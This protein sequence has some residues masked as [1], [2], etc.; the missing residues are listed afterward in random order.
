MVSGCILGLLA[1]VLGAF[2]SHGLK[3]RI[4]A[5]AL[6]SFRTGVRYQMYHGLLLILVGMMPWLDNKAR[7]ILLFLVLIGLLFFSGSIYMLSTREISGLD[8]SAIGF[9][10]PVGG[11]LLILSWLVLIYKIVKNPVDK[12]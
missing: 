10:T 8:F 11:M 3:A 6:E 7:S 12:N 4:D 9:I 1:V 5:D 2:A